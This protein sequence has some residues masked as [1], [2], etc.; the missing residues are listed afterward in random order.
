MSRM[1]FRAFV[2]LAAIAAWS[3]AYAAAGPA[4]QTSNE[5]AVTVKV[6]PKNLAGSTWEFD[7]TFDTHTQ[8]LN[9]D[10]LKSAVLVS[11]NGAQAS[12]VSWQAD[13]PGGHHRKGVLRFNALT[14]PPSVVELRINRP[15]ESKPRSFKW[16]LK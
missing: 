11:A 4:P 1:I 12:P 16:E 13:P 14:P 5:N 2:L 8:P 9:D 15:G 3:R 6:T 7:V 10:L